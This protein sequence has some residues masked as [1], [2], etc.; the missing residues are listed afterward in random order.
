MISPYI[1]LNNSAAMRCD[2]K[3]GFT[4]RFVDGLNLSHTPI[5]ICV[6]VDSAFLSVANITSGVAGNNQMAL[7]LWVI[8]GLTGVIFRIIGMRSQRRNGDFH[9][10]MKR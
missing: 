7:V 10:Y 4:N 3:N 6:D 2:V 1:N 9:P 5:T 8:P